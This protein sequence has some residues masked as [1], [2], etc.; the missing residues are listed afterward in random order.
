[1]IEGGLAVLLN[2]LAIATITFALSNIAVSAVVTVLAQRFVEFEVQS[3]K[4]I[5]WLLVTVPWFAVF[6]VAICFVY[7]FYYTNAF[8]NDNSMAHWHHMTSF[9]LLSWHSV[10]LLIAFAYIAHVFVDK[11]VALVKHKNE[12]KLLTSYS[13]Q[14]QQNTYKIDSPMPNAFTSGFFTKNC[15][16]TSGILDKTTADEQDII[17]RHEQ[18]HAAFSDPLKK[19]VFSIFSAFFLPF[20]AN[21]LKLH[22]TLAMEQAAD[23]KVLNDGTSPTLVASTLVKIAKLNA[24]NKQSAVLN[25]DLVA[26]FGVEV[27]EQRVYFLL[28]QLELTPANRLLTFL[29]LA[30]T[31]VMSMLSIDG[32]HHLMETVFNH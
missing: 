13:E 10:T 20:I 32:V 4:A 6:C 1:M 24:S 17:F 28:G 22:M 12:L 9:E 19:W 25:S 7:P 11:I 3:R 15:F 30:V 2:I 27:L 31:V 21:R 5:L 26:N 14:L 29:F 8:F 16:V 18:A 23:L